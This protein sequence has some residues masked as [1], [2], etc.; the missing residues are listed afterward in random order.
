MKHRARVLLVALIVCACLGAVAVAWASET[1]KLS[2]YFTPN[3]LG[4]PTN[5]Y[6]RATFTSNGGAAVPVSNVVAYGPAGL[7]VYVKGTRVCDKVKLEA[8]GPSGCPSDSRIGFGGGVGLVE[9]AKQLVKD[10]FTL[11]FFLAPK[12]NGHLTILIY[13]N[14]VSPVSVQLVLVAKEIRGP[15]PYGFGVSVEIPPIPTL[16]GAAYA[17]LESSYLS[18][19]S[20]KVAYYQ[21]IHGKR[22]LVHVKGLTVPKTCPRG[23]FPFEVT[24]SFEDGTS[25]TDRYTSP[26]PRK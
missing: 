11:D 4:A 21:T 3:R 26:C 5:L 16:P 1:F 14:A 8:E 12:E 13:V 2:T 19:G 25:N 6:A 24:I 7:G 22:Q 17:A 9:L 20:T 23:G 10:P 15:K 18:V